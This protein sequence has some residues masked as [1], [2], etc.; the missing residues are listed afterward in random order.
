M[1]GDIIPKVIGLFLMPILTRYLSP[2]D[3]GIMTYT[4]SIALF[5]Y[6]FTILSLNSYLLRHYS[7]ISSDI[8]KKKFV[9]NLFVFIMSCP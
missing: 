4:E 6:A 9:G 5:V 2:E 3:Y 7:D 1:I 8:E